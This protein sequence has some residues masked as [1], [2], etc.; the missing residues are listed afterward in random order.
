MPDVL[1]F[2]A[3][4]GYETDDTTYPDID[5]GTIDG[6]YDLTTL[7]ARHFDIDMPD[8][9]SDEIRHWK[10]PGRYRITIERLNG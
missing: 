9:Y 8:E 6:I 5:F 2:E 3:T 4:I 10:L 1:T 7:T